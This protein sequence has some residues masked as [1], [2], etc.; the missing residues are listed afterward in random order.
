MPEMNSEATV[1]AAATRFRNESRVV[2]PL[3][4]EPEVVD[5]T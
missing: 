1:V 5:F 4:A 2:V 3:T